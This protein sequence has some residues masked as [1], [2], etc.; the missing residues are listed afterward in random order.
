M[1]RRVLPMLLLALALL[2]TGCARKL[3]DP[4]THAEHLR[5]G[6]AYEIQ[7]D[8][9]RAAAEYLKAL[10]QEPQAAFLL[11]NVRFAAGQEEESLRLYRSAQ[12]HM[13]DDAHLNNNLAWVLFNQGQRRAD[14]VQIAEAEQ[15]ARKAV[16]AASPELR[17]HC[18]D[19]LEQI[20]L[21]LRRMRGE[22]ISRET[23]PPAHHNKARSGKG[24]APSPQASR[25]G[26]TPPAMPPAQPR[27]AAFTAQP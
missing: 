20:R 8:P 19:T 24:A 10:P 26:A 25:T 5:L 18:E 23:P 13:P 27:S 9:E 11:G 6:M 12:E 4:L 3:P 14:A 1:I 22:T 15:L 2:L 21:S 17:G 16:A 7:N